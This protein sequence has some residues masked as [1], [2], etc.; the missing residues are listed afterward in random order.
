MKS[1]V[2]FV[3]KYNCAFVVFGN[4]IADLHHDFQPTTRA[5]QHRLAALRKAREIQISVE[6]ALTLNPP[7]GYVFCGVFANG[8][9]RGV[10]SGFRRPGRRSAAEK[11]SDKKLGKADWLLFRLITGLDATF[12]PVESD[13]KNKWTCPRGGTARITQPHQTEDGL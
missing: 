12:V 4:G 11:K 13:W 8:D 7:K 2:K 5:E 10:T 3:E 9:V 6:E 1:T